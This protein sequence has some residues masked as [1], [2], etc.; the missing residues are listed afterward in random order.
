MCI[1][2]GGGAIGTGG[3]RPVDDDSGNGVGGDGERGAEDLA[4]GRREKSAAGIGAGGGDGVRGADVRAI[5][6]V[7]DN[8]AGGAALDNPVIAV[9]RD[10]DP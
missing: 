8:A 1:A 2:I 5:A 7:E 4:A 3:A 10:L 6:D 9:R